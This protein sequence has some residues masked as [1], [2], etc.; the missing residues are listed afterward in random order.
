MSFFIEFLRVNLIFRYHFSLTFTCRQNRAGFKATSFLKLPVRVQGWLFFR[1]SCMD[2]IRRKTHIFF[3]NKI[4]QKTIHVFLIFLFV[5]KKSPR[6]SGP[7][8]EPLQGSP[9]GAGFQWCVFSRT[10]LGDSVDKKNGA[11]VFHC[12]RY[13]NVIHRYTIPIIEM[14]V[15][16]VRDDEQLHEKPFD[17]NHMDGSNWVTELCSIYSRPM[18]RVK[19]WKCVVEI[20]TQVSRFFKWERV[21]VGVWMSNWGNFVSFSNKN[22][23]HQHCHQY[24][25]Q[26]YATASSLSQTRRDIQVLA[27]VK[28]TGEIWWCWPHNSSPGIDSAAKQMILLHLRNLTWNVN[29]MV[30]KGNLLFQGPFSV[31]IDGTHVQN[32]QSL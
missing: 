9:T 22:H 30:S 26:Q 15:H 6:V 5:W 27:C 13:R 18:Q 7:T 11:D 10:G 19:I 12:K 31:K 17:V 28:S 3:P 16:Y 21:R 1:V 29:M 32:T 8:T 20:V 14:R 24:H 4:H 23:H 25:H 2:T